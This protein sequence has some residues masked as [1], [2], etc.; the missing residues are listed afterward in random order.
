M[1]ITQGLLKRKLVGGHIYLGRRRST[2]YKLLYRG[3]FERLADET[4]SSRVGSHQLPAYD[5]V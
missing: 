5:L 1:S 2:C 3:L 4:F